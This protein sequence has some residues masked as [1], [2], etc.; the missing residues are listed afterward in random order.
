MRLRVFGVH[1]LLLAVYG[2]FPLLVW[3]GFHVPS[4][5]YRREDAAWATGLGML[6][7]LGFIYFF[8][9]GAFWIRY[10]W[11]GLGLLE[12]LWEIVPAVSE[13]DFASIGGI[14]GAL[15]IG[16]AMAIW[17]ERK[18]DSAALNPGAFWFEGELKSI[19]RIRARIRAGEIWVQAK[20]RRIDEKGLFLLHE[21]TSGLR[22]G[23]SL[24]FELEHEG[25]RVGGEGRVVAF[26]LDALPGLGLQFLP[27]D[28][29]H[30]Q[31]YTAL[32]RRLRGEG[33]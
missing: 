32:V 29:Y 25:Q 17:L 23:Q 19:P 22:A 9:R 31:Q 5:L 18:V 26:F 12:L 2:L 15:L 28:L 3:S 21:A 6:F 24:E 14:L 30:F 33:L 7:C 4:M 8:R 16:V 1:R 11:G 13:R 27:K 20:I 10:G